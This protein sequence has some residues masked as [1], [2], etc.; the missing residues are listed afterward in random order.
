MQSIIWILVFPIKT[1]HRLLSE[2]DIPNQ[3]KIFN[4]GSIA[5]WA[6]SQVFFLHSTSEPIYYF[7]WVYL[8]WDI[9]GKIDL[10]LAL[11]WGNICQFFQVRLKIQNINQR[12]LIFS[13]TLNF[14]VK[15]GLKILNLKKTQIEMKINTHKT[16]QHFIYYI[17]KNKICLFLPPKC[18][19]HCIQFLRSVHLYL[20]NKLSWS[21]H[22]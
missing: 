8:W 16:L 9:L 10:N 17:K 12:F 11:G 6:E 1:K 2:M 22:I 13:N 15:I 3:K 19:I 7:W 20:Y 21:C 4:D 18:S 14:I 5:V